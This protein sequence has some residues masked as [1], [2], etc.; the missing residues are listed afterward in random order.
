[1]ILLFTVNESTRKLQDFHVFSYKELDEV[2]LNFILFFFSTKCSFREDSKKGSEDCFTFESKT[3]S[4]SFYKFT[5]LYPL[6]ILLHCKRFSLGCPLHGM[7]W[8]LFFSNVLWYTEQ[9]LSCEGDKIFYILFNIIR[10]WNMVGK[11]KYQKHNLMF[12]K[13]CLILT[14]NWN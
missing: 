13:G 12:Y 14:I 4:S 5:Y 6:W 1:M 9:L 10:E 3:I 8:A 11:C 7:F 2:G